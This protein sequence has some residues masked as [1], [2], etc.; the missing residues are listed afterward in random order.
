MLAHRASPYSVKLGAMPCSLG[1]PGSLPKSR[2]LRTWGHS[3]L[4][5]SL[6]WSRDLSRALKG[7]AQ[8]LAQLGTLK[9]SRPNGDSVAKKPRSSDSPMS[10]TLAITTA[11]WFLHFQNKTIL[12]IWN[13]YCYFF[14][15]LSQEIQKMNFHFMLKFTPISGNWYFMNTEISIFNQ[16]HSWCL[17]RMQEKTITINM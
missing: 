5:G 17:T 15:L 1:N 11:A 2:G 9:P 3:G 14:L 10:C 8:I 6:P 4:P 12:M 13:L 7:V 16:L